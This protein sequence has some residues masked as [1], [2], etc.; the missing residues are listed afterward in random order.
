MALL[1]IMEAAQHAKV[2]ERTVRR[3]IDNGSL[4]F[5]TKGVKKLVRISDLERAFAPEGAKANTPPV[6]PCRVIALTNQKGG[7]GKTT[8]AANLASALAAQGLRVLAVDCDAQGNL[9]QALGSDPDTLAVTLYNVLIERVPI[10]QA[11]LTPILGYPT[12]SLIG[13][14]LDLAAADH[15]LAGVVAREMRLRQVLE[16]MLP[17]YDFV[18]ID[19]PPALG[20]LTLNALTAA[21]EIIVPVEMG[22]FSLRGVG[23]L[24]DT[25]EEVRTVNPSLGRVRALANRSDNTNLSVDVQAELKSAFQNDLF[26]TVIRRSVRV[27]EAQAA[28]SPITLHR[29]KDPAA[30][31]YVALAQEV[32][33]DVAA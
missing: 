19:C 15:Q 16:P 33:D 14:S 2:A 13:S 6:G 5:V 21:T 11:I 9:T 7:V 22:V 18:L 12:L 20:L 24:M 30:K 4:P 8:T 28:S 27:G 31:D 32:L 23:R 17:Q 3:R 1:T 26:K 10:T 25:I 29:P